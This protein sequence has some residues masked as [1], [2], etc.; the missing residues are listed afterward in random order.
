MQS[1]G[2]AAWRLRLGYHQGWPVHGLSWGTVR[3]G[4]ALFALTFA[5][6]KETPAVPSS[7]ENPK[8]EAPAYLEVLN[9]PILVERARRRAS[10]ARPA[11]LSPESLE[12]VWQVTKDVI[13]ADMSDADARRTLKSVAS[14]PS[15]DPWIRAKAICLLTLIDADEGGALMLDALRSAESKSLAELMRGICV[16]IPRDVS[17]ANTKLVEWLVGQLRAPEV[18]DGAA[19]LC[20]RLRLPEFESRFWEAYPE[21]DEKTKIA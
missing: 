7:A 12:D 19:R 9:E 15:N 1:R 17:I 4:I 3:A 8:P 5:C 11:P 6:R 10:E 2:F 14:A 20:A 18:G 13:P 21:V 16:F